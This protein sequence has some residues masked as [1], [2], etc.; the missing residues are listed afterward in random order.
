MKLFTGRILAPASKSSSLRALICCNLTVNNNSVLIH[1][2]SK[3]NDV[4]AGLDLICSLG[5]FSYTWDNNSLLLISKGV[6]REYKESFII[7]VKESGF[8]ARVFVSL[9]TYFSKEVIITG[10]ATLNKR[11]LG[12][13]TFAKKIG[14]TAS[15]SKLPVKIHGTISAREL[16]IKEKSSSQFLSGLLFTLPLLKDDSLLILDQVVSKPY[17]ELTLSYLE[18]SGINFTRI[19]KDKLLIQGNQSYDITELT[20]ETDWSSLSYIIVLGLLAGDITI[21]NIIDADFLPDRIILNVL[22]EIGANYSFPNPETLIVK[23]SQIKGYTFDLTGN[24]DLAPALV[25]LAIGASSPS[26]LTNCYRLRDKESDRLFS[27]IE[28]LKTLKVEYS[29]SDDSLTIFPSKV[30]GGEVHA[31]DDHR[32]AM[33]AL[34]LNAISSDKITID[35]YEC[36]DKSYPGFLNDMN[37]LGVEI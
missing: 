12:I 21:T 10:E 33:S 35:N 11:N 8:L 31:Y 9:G 25:A 17:I 7:N 1:N 27:I 22:D 24:P 2:C 23:K 32:I 13:E 19:D 20:P 29:Y 37:M 6:K 16:H 36:I 3:C 4:L 28:M 34:I 14:L 26:Q 30:S 15:D 5:G 18:R